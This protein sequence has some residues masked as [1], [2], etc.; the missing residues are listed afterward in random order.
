MLLYLKKIIKK[1]LNLTKTLFGYF[2]EFLKLINPYLYFFYYK[3]LKFSKN[4]EKRI[5]FKYPLI[6]KQIIYRKP[7]LELTKLVATIKFIIKYDGSAGVKF[8]L[9]PV[10]VDVG[11][12]VSEI[13]SQTI[14]VTFEDNKDELCKN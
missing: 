4:I 6:D 1:L 14:K 10:T 3:N 5:G 2:L 12:G 13:N 11:G 9:S 7:K 8:I